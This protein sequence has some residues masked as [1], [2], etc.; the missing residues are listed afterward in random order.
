MYLEKYFNVAE[1]NYLRA[2]VMAAMKLTV[3]RKPIDQ[4]SNLSK[5]RGRFCTVC[6][7]RL[8][9]VFRK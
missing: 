3:N 8:R 1:L 9:F 4:M 2:G 6:L 7:E 5:V